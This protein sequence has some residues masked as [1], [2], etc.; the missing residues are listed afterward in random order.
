MEI[1]VAREMSD[2][3]GGFPEGYFCTKCTEPTRLTRVFSRIGYKHSS[4]CDEC[5]GLVENIGVPMPVG[6]LDRRCAADFRADLR[7]S[8]LGLPVPGSHGN[9]FTFCPQ[10]SR[11]ISTAS[12]QAFYATDCKLSGSFPISRAM[13]LS[14]LSAGRCYD[15]RHFLGKVARVS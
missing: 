8:P 9:P 12:S 14:K 11:A 4:C 10:F 15:T 13:Q 5:C 2:G 7:I 6:R 1:R 3:V